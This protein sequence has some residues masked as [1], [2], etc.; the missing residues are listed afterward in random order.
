LSQ[1]PTPDILAKYHVIA[2]VGLSDDSTKHSFLVASY[3]KRHGYR[4]IPINPNIS[5]VLGEKSYSNLLA[6][7]PRLQQTIDIVDIFRK[8][9]DVPPIVQ[10]AIE[11]KQRFGRPFVVWMQRGI[12]NEA[13]AQAAVQAGLVVVMDKCM[14]TEHH[15]QR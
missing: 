8:S 1:N 9:E 3:L 7:P 13:A 4:I 11:L 6:I 12:V 14:M 15:L 5:S 10:Q 2:V